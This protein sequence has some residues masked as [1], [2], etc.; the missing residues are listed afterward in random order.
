MADFFSMGGYGFYIWCSFAMTLLLL[1]AEPL[2]LRWRHKALLQRLVR[3]A[4]I[5]SGA[6]E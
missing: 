1:I 3:M 5:N 6:G 4:V 2:W